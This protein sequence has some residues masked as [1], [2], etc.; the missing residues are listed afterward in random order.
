MAA[1][2]VRAALPGDAKRRLE[3]LRPFRSEPAR[4]SRPSLPEAPGNPAWNER[5]NPVAEEVHPIPLPAWPGHV[6]NP[7]RRPPRQAVLA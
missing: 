1:D 5:G 2:P 7:P 4:W 3:S 6:P